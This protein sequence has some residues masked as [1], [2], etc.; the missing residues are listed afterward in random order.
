MWIHNVAAMPLLLPL[1]LIR[2]TGAWE[3]CEGQGNISLRWLDPR[4]ERGVSAPMIAEQGVP[5]AEKR[6]SLA[7]SPPGR[8]LLWLPVLGKAGHMV[9]VQEQGSHTCPASEGRRVTL[10]Q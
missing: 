2:G 7:L 9:T 5:A 3:V 4:L 10:G 6:D 1:A 8:T